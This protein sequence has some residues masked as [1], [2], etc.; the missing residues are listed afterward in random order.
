VKGRADRPR[1]GRVAPGAIDGLDR[2]AAGLLGLYLV[3]TAVAHL[4]QGR[5]LYVDLL[6]LEVPA[7]LALAAGLLLLRLVAARRRPRRSE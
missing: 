6:G 1:S 4:S 5:W 7:P 2:A 3:G